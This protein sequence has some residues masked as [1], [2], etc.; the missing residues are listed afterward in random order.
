MESGCVKG[1]TKE[2]VSRNLQPETEKVRAQADK[3]NGEEARE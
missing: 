3:A 2:G 1:I